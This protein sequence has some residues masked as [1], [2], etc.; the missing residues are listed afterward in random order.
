[1]SEE[2]TRQEVISLLSDHFGKPITLEISTDTAIPVPEIQADTISKD[3]SAAPSN[4]ATA[5]VLEA[6]GGGEVVT[7]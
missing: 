6:F 3:E 7:L 5:Q 1:M 4:P 2:S